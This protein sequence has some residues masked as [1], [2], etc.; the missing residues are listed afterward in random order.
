MTR[1]DTNNAQP[2]IEKR[3][4][5]FSQDKKQ[6]AAMRNM[7]KELEIE[8]D[9]PSINPQ[10]KFEKEDRIEKLKAALKKIPIRNP[11]SEKEKMRITVCRSIKLALDKIH[12]ELPILEKYLNR[13]TIKTGDWCS[14]SPIP[15]DPVEWEL[16]H[17]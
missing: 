7:I 14:Y 9:N 15:S 11:K 4:Y 17:K 3:L 2:N 5:D 16:F 10:E 6:R 1:L 12:K 8:I 13:S